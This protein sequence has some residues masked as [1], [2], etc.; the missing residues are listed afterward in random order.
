[1]N[2]SLHAEG[3]GRVEGRPEQALECVRPRTKCP[4]YLGL[5]MI[6]SQNPS[7]SRQAWEVTRERSLKSLSKAGKRK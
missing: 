6:P 2:F 3:Q 1:M 4:F 5:R 7:V